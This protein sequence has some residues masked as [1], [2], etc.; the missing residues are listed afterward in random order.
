MRYGGRWFA[1]SQNGEAPIM[2]F[3]VRQGTVIGMW[4]GIVG[5]W[6]APDTGKP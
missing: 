5:A 4:A 6:R 1:L 3:A 2:S